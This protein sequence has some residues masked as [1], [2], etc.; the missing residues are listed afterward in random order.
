MGALIDMYKHDRTDAG[1]ATIRTLRKRGGQLAALIADAGRGEL[2]VPTPLLSNISRDLEAGAR[3]ASGSADLAAGL[4]RTATRLR[5]RM[6][7]SARGS[8]F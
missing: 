6:A 8:G 4:R 1:A 3:Q 7:I 2:S 5:S